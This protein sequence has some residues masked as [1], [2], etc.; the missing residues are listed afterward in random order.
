[1]RIQSIH[2]MLLA[3]VAIAALVGLTAVPIGSVLAAVPSSSYSSTA[4]NISTNRNTVLDAIAQAKI[5]LAH[6]DT[7]RAFDQVARA[8]VA[9]LNLEELH[10]D[11]NLMAALR[12]VE[13]ARQILMQGGDLSTAE[14]QL[15]QATADLNLAFALGIPG[16]SPG[17]TAGPP[18]GV[19]VYD[20]SGHEIGPVT[21]VVFGPNGDVQRVVISVA[22]G[23]KYVSAPLSEISWNQNRLTLNESPAQIEQDETYRPAQAGFGSSTPPR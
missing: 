11:P 20:A 6:R 10:H 3:S 14:Q 18:V 12:R 16:Q 21:T 22:P 17:V 2:P 1:M 8:E 4:E 15:A 9:L 5:A 23:E 19:V 13:T 7:R